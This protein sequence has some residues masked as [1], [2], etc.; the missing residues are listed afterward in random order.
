MTMYCTYTFA[1]S[2]K[3][4]PLLASRSFRA[5]GARGAKDH[6]IDILM[7]F[8]PARKR[9][10]SPLAHFAPQAR[11]AQTTIYR[12]RAGAVAG[13]RT[14]LWCTTQNVIVEQSRTKNK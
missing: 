13:V 2:Y 6:V 12:G 4:A 8:L 1:L 3:Q 10:A 5:A 9:P 14:G 7:C 11:E